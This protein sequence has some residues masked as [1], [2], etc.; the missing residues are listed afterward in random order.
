VSPEDPWLEGLFDKAHPV[1]EPSPPEL[2]KRSKEHYLTFEAEW[3]LVFKD[4]L[5]LP[6]E[7]PEHLDR[8]L[9][10]F[11][12]FAEGT[13]IRSLLD[14]DDSGVPWAPASIGNNFCGS[15]EG[16]EWRSLADWDAFFRDEK[17]RDS[18]DH[19]EVRVQYVT[20]GGKRI[21][22]KSSFCSMRERLFPEGSRTMPTELVRKIAEIHCRRYGAGRPIELKGIDLGLYGP[23]GGAVNQSRFHSRS[24]M[25]WQIVNPFSWGGPPLAVRGMRNTAQSILDSG[26]CIGELSTLKLRLITHDENGSPLE[27]KP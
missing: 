5:E 9:A 21:C 26:E 4:P 16:T 3:A 23:D 24:A 1:N 10:R 14:G 19:A 2:A 15:G 25:L 22:F 20:A 6:L 18:L 11:E 17:L 13:W 12:P 27:A 7:T 8:V